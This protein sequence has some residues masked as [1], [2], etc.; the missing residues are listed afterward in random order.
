MEQKPLFRMT[1]IHKYFPG[2]KALEEVDFAVRTG[3]VH[4][5]IGEN[6][7]GKST[8]V[9]LMTGVHQPT[10]GEM[11]YAGE[12]VE[13]KSPQDSQ[14][15]G[16]AAIHQEAI[17]F[18]ELSIT[19]NV[20]LGHPLRSGPLRTLR[21]AEMHTRTRELMEQLELKL[22]P[23]RS[24]LSLSTAE[25]HMVEI[26]KAL[27][28]NA[29]IVIMDEPTSALSL[30]EVEELF[31]I[32]R[33]LRDDG[34]AIVFISHKFD[35]IRAIADTY[36]VL[37]DGRY[38][39]SGKLDDTSDDE[40]VRMMV[41]RSLEQL[42]PKTRARIGD[43]LLSAESL[44][45]LGVFKDISFT[46]HAGEI[47]G[48]FGLVG[49]G[50]SEVMRGI[51][52]IDVLSRGTVRIGDEEIRH[53]RPR[54]M[55]ADVIAM[56]PEDRQTQGAVLE[57]TIDHNVTL[58]SLRQLSKGGVLNSAREAAL[59]SS[60]CEQLEV[61]ATAWSQLVNQLSGG[62]QQKVV[63][64]KWLA[65]KPRILILDE[66]TK[67]IDVATK[68]AVHQFMCDLAEQGIGIILVSS[69]LPEI[70]GMSDRIIIMHEGLVTGEFP[71]AEATSENVM[72][73][74][75]GGLSVGSGT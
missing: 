59:T 44:E 62:N 29:E 26:L 47:L 19:E 35:E 10:S 34:K 55:M 18:P 39:G 28:H 30:R 49:A 50:R 4:A 74:A 45:S 51:F 16:I 21:W 67:G 66:P 24:V 15:I 5:L 75:T 60:Y 2:I 56:V 38:V 52:G 63:L 46:L 73:A 53:P 22:D 69:E 70:L 43:P 27:S 41:G 9:K 20:F 40:I 7:A 72:A 17:M 61:R 12:P 23:K 11:H 31:A 33:K 68:A 58:P 71:R 25:R 8:L 42:Y 1:R 65:T 64:A 37:R 36:T 54:Q 3:E 6:G 48:F 32:I 13:F 57:M 14:N